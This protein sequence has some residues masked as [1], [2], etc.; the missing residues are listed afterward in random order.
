LIEWREGG[1][2]KHKLSEYFF[3]SN[4]SVDFY[5]KRFF[6]NIYENPK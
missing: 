6:E 4:P 2:L 3:A 5:L 1:I